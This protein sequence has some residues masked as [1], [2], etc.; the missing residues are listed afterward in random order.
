MMVFHHRFLFEALAAIEIETSR[1]DFELWC[2]ASRSRERFA[3]FF[4]VVPLCARA[5]E[6]SGGVV[7][8]NGEFSL[9]GCER[10]EKQLK[11]ER[12]LQRHVYQ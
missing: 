5:C 12:G 7:L 2:R 3:F 6:K 10:I 4:C 9:G 8:E 1:S 11:S